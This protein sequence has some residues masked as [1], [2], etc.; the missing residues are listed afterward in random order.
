[1]NRTRTRI[2]TVTVG[3]PPYAVTC[4]VPRDGIGFFEAI[5]LTVRG[6]IDA[7]R[8]RD[9]ADNEHTHS[10]HRLLHAH[11]RREAETVRRIDTAAS[12]VDREIARLRPIVERMTEPVPVI[13]DT[14]ALAG[15]A[16]AERSE[17]ANQVRSART[18]AAD[19]R[20]REARRDVATIELEELRSV[21]ESIGVEG[22]DV[23]RQWREA[24]SMRAARYTR[25][26]SGRRGAP[27]ASSPAIA[28]YPHADGPSII[29]GPETR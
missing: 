22:E 18:A 6:R 19:A 3:I 2:R 11:R 28:A 20:Q 29:R 16:P 9:V 23:R 12:A 14:A 10:L 17:W 1:M 15:L 7:R 5:A 25:A 21:R 26:R 27:V 24:Y 13:P 4:D 8:T